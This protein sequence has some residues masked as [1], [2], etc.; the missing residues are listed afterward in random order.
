[1]SPTARAAL[2]A[3]VLA[4]LL[5]LLATPAVAGPLITCAVETG[6]DWYTTPEIALSRDFD[7]EVGP[8]VFEIDLETGI[9]TDRFAN[10]AEPHRSGVLAVLRK[11]DKA[12]LQDFVGWDAANRLY[13]VARVWVEGMPFMVADRYGDAFAGKCTEGRVTP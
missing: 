10:R 7:P 4:L 2:R 8:P 6:F 12:A 13:V 11:A 5:G 1:M 9:Y 3:P